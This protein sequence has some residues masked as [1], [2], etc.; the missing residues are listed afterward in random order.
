MENADKAVSLPLER[1]PLQMY[2]G[3]ILA[4]QA[5]DPCKHPVYQFSTLVHF[6]CTYPSER[7]AVR[8]QAYTACYKRALFIS[9]D[10]IFIDDDIAFFQA[11]LAML[12][13]MPHVVTSRST[14]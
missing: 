12:P 5:D 9:R 8:S 13:V 14:M 2:P 11:R 6:A 1:L 10:P 4:P 3:D 7:Q